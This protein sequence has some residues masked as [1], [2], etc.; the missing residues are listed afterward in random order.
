[1]T[2]RAWIL[3]GICVVLALVAP[4]VSAANALPDPIIRESHIQTIVT[5]L[6]GGQ[7]L[8]EYTVFNDSPAPQLKWG[9]VEVYP[10]IIA[11]QIPLPTN[12][13]DILVGV[14]G[15]E[16]VYE[17]DRHVLTKAEYE[18]EYGFPSPFAGD[19]VILDWFDMRVPQPSDS[20]AQVP[21]GPVGNPFQWPDHIPDFAM[22]PPT[23]PFPYYWLVSTLPPVDGPYANVWSDFQFNVGD[24]PLPGGGL[25]GGGVPFNPTAG[26]EIPEPATMSLFALALV[27]LGGAVRRRRR[28]A[29]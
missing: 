1:M 28:G 20:G 27:G 24:P 2:K 22:H 25:I 12:W 13:Q 8:Y 9:E 21:I 3:S 5:D 7:W 17:W 29:S 19:H 14:G 10:S 26:G 15:P 11:Y 18:L 23:E 6:G 16:P 4:G